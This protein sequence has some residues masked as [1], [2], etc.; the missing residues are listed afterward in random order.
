MLVSATVTYTDVSRPSVAS[1]STN[2]T[3]ATQAVEKEASSVQITLSQAGQ[4]YLDSG[5]SLANASMSSAQQALGRLDQMIRS[6]HSDAKQQAEER[7]NILKAQMRQ[8]MQIKALLSHKELAQ[9]LAQLAH[10]LA[11]AVSQYMQS[12]GSNAANTAVG[13][14][15]L[16]S[17]QN[18]A[19][20]QT[21]QS[22]QNTTA[23]TEDSA[24]AATTTTDEQASSSF[25]QSDTNSDDHQDFAQTVRTLAEQ[26]KNMLQDSQKHLE[27]QDAQASSETSNTQ[28]TLQSAEQLVIKA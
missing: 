10:Q 1:D 28:S 5:S 8:L 3:A 13:T 25:N 14:V 19:D 21:P 11:A 27:K 9:Q 16:S 18:G 20:A 26:I 23:Q 12:G 6:D 22:D 4:D 15:I 7:V 24:Q 17:S 2:A